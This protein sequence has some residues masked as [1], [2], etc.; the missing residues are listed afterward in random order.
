MD[1][2]TDGCK[3]F[4]KDCLKGLLNG[5]MVHHYFINHLQFGLFFVFSCYMK[6]MAPLLPV[7]LFCFIFMRNLLFFSIVKVT[8]VSK[9]QL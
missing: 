1:G 8:F 2:R 5:L 6:S 7:L 9:M 3:H 4:V